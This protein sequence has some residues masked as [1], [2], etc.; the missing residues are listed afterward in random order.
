MTD[1]H[2]FLP[3]ANPRVSGRSCARCGRAEDHSIHHVEEAYPVP[4]AVRRS[5]DY[6]NEHK[7]RWQVEDAAK[8]KT[9]KGNR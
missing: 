4:L 3:H 8:D 1:P 7:P 2:I 6:V 9:E 5:I